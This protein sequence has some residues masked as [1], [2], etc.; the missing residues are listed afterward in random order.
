MSTNVAVMEIKL[1]KSEL[2]LLKRS[3]YIKDTE[4]YL[5]YLICFF[6]LMLVL[7]NT[8]EL[9]VLLLFILTVLVSIKVSMRLMIAHIVTL[10][11]IQSQT[12]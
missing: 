11:K 1:S 4:K 9:L 10:E 3:D 12:K 7:V 2:E 5:K 8:T 6:A